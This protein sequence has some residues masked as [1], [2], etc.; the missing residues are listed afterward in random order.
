MNI[1]S[2]FDVQRSENTSVKIKYK[3]WD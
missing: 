1:L 3:D 2:S